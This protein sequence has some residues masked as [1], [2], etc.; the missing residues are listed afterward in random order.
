MTYAV[1]G[2]GR[3]GSAIARSLSA[4]GLRVVTWSSRGKRDFSVALERLGRLDRLRGVFLCIPEAALDARGRALSMYDYPYIVVSGS[5]DPATL[6][7]AAKTFHPLMG[8]SGVG[9][10]TLAGVPVGVDAAPLGALARKL[11]ARPFRL[12]KDRTLY[13]A[14]AVL[15]GAGVLAAWADACALLSAAGVAR[16]RAVL[17]PIAH[18]ALTRQALTGPVVRGDEATIAAHRRA[19]RRAAPEVLRTYEALIASMRRMRA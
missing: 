1:F 9:P 10:K 12:P 13:H 18:A 6:P 2:M 17:E 5:V 15:G 11:G 19:I 3:V 7:F 8:F 16:P 4:A 14:A